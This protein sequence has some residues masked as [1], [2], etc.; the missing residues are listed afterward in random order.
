MVYANLIICYP[1]NVYTVVTEQTTILDQSEEGLVV[2]AKCN[3]EQLTDTNKMYALKILTNYYQ[4]I[5]TVTKVK[6]LS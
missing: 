3:R 6:M 2:K 1:F 4:E 5:S